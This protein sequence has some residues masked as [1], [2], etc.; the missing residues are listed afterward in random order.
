[1]SR[2]LSGILALLVVVLAPSLAYGHAERPTPSPPREGEVPSVAR[3][4]RQ[5]PVLDVCKSRVNGARECRFRD[6]QAAVNAAPNGALIRIWPG[7]YEERPSRAA[8]RFP[9]DNPDGTFSYEFHKKHPNSENLIAIVGKKNLTLLGMGR[10]PRDVVIDVGFTKHVGIRGDRSDGLIIKNLSMWH[11]FD[12]GIYVLETSGLLIDE[13]VSGY[14]REYAFLTFADDHVLMRNC[15][16]TGSGDGG[17]YPGGSAE[18][19]GRVSQEIS[20]CKS[21]HNVLGYSGTQGDHVWVHDTEFFDNAVG[22]V[23][24]S[25]TDHPNYPQ[26]DLTLERNKFY[27]NNFNPYSADS[28]LKATVFEGYYLIPVG[29]GAWLVSGHNNLV[30]NNWIWGHDRAGVWQSSGQGLVIGPTEE[31]RAL[32]FASSNNR[33]IANRFHPPKGTRG[34]ANTTD[35]YYDG[36]GLNNCFEGNVGFDGEAPSSDNP[37]LPPCLDPVVGTLP[38]IASVPWPPNFVAQAM[39]LYENGEPLCWQ[40]GVEPCIWG[41][42]P[43]PEN[44]RNLPEGMRREWPI[45]PV[46]GPVT[47]RLVLKRR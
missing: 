12:H 43:K 31:P 16:A 25:E 30:Q 4:K 41:P 19:P 26:N 11:A 33:Y 10:R 24:D 8:K 17:L 28:D 18:T 39:G 47:C 40:L 3:I 38:S 1:M 45:P 5:H 36:L 13:V 23:T 20:H 29:V 35:V 32:P 42:G 22:L 34:E 21:Y 6:I 2:R 44:A 14:S 37:V 9:P 27:D 7:L 46:C 15:E